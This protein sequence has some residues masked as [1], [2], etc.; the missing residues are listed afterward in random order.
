MIIKCIKCLF[1]FSF[2]KT[3]LMQNTLN[4][5]IKKNIFKDVY[6]QMGE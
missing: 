6:Q 5:I 1:W 4:Y 3:S 2:L